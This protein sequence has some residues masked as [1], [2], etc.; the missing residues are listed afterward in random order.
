MTSNAVVVDTV[1]ERSADKG[2]SVGE[3]SNLFAFDNRIADN[4][5]GVQTKD[6]STSYLFNNDFEGNQK[7][8]DAYKKNW[9]YDDGGHVFVSKSRFV[10]SVGGV[11]A[12]GRST[13]QVSDCYVAGSPSVSGD[14][15][16]RHFD[17][18]SEERARDSRPGSL[19][20]VFED[21]EDLVRP[22]F[23]RIDFSRRGPL[24]GRR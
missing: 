13:I 6:S 20:A 3:A 14:V 10:N 18:G 16:L 7:A 1:I 17:Q 23:L 9:R 5:I 15:T 22:Y 8:A 19:P 2:I 12:K 21:I 24:D 4:V 11:A